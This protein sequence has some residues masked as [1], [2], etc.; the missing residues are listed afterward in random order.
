MK[1]D[2]EEIRF[3]IEHRRDEKKSNMQFI[4]DLNVE[5]WD[6]MNRGDVEFSL[7]IDAKIK[8]KK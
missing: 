7:I 3:R 4:N 1:R 2:K 8:E 5:I 6:L